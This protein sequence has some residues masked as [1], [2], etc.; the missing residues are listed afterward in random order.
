M[1]TGLDWR[2]SSYPEDACLGFGLPEE[3]ERQLKLASQSGLHDAA[4]DHLRAAWQAAPGHPAV[5][6]GLYRFYFY[7]HRLAEALEVAAACLKQVAGELKIASDW[8]KVRRQDADFAN[9]EAS[10]PRFYLFTLKAYAYLKLRLGKL[11]E[12]KAALAKLLELDPGDKLGGKGLVK[13]LS[14]Q[15]HGL[16]DRT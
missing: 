10:L 16:K 9:L 2:A 6:V 11:E 1:A 4:L 13:V 8:R 3:A 7:R 5:Y 15:A 12:G 14:R